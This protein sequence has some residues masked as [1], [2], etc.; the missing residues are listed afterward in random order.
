MLSYAGRQG[1]RNLRNYSDMPYGPRSPE[2]RAA[3]SFLAAWM[4]FF[5]PDIIRYIFECTKLRMTQTFR[6]KCNYNI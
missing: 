4:L 2:A 3:T 6:Y 5:T 1:I